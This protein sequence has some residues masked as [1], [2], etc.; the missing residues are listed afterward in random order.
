MLRPFQEGDVAAIVDLSLRAWE[1][2]FASFAEVLGPELYS[3]LYPDWKTQQSESVRE[4]LEANETWVSEAG[5]Q[6]TGFVNVIFDADEKA[7]E[8]YMI[9]VDP[10]FQRQSLATDLT[11]L[12]V[13]EMQRRGL[14]M[15]TVATG[16]DPGHAPARRVYEKAGFIPFPQVLYSKILQ[17]TSDA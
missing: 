4:A 2:V 13:E 14:T 17:P 11:Q 1:P 9:A 15:A 7:G 3:R 8:I 6:V 16:G 5:G 10:T 12:A